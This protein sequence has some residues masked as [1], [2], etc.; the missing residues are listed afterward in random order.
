[1]TAIEAPS[2]ETEGVKGKTESSNSLRN[3]ETDSRRSKTDEGSPVC[4]ND[5]CTE[6]KGVR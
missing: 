2:Q 5:A 6:P 1:M 4:S 3:L